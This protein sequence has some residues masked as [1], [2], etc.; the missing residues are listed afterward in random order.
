MRTRTLGA[1]LAATV[2]LSASLIAADLDLS[3]VK[4]LVNPKAAAKA[5]KSAEYRG[6]QVFFC[7]GNCQA[8]FKEDAKPFA[9]SANHQLAA[10]GQFSQKSCPLSGGPLNAEKTVD[11]AGVKVAFCCEKCQGKVAAAEGAAQ[12]ELVFGNAA[13]EKGFAK[14]EVKSE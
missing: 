4:C 7:C 8:K 9:V 12:T 10:T 5:D 14:A 2:L 1:L 11:V 13:F 6:S 3:N